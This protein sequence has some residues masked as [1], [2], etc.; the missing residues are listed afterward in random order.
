M[1][2]ARQQRLHTVWFHLYKIL[3]NATKASDRKQIEGQGWVG[4]KD[5]AGH[6]ENLVVMIMFTFLII[7]M[8]SRMYTLTSKQITQF[9]YMHFICHLTSVKLLK[10]NTKKYQEL[11]DGSNIFVGSELCCSWWALETLPALFSAFPEGQFICAGFWLKPHFTFTLC[12]RAAPGCWLSLASPT[13]W[14]GILPSQLR[15]TDQVTN[16][17]Q[18]LKGGKISKHG[19]KKTK[20]HKSPR[21]MVSTPS[22]PAAAVDGWLQSRTGWT[23]PTGCKLLRVS[24]C[25][26]TSWGY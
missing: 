12:N 21:P 18:T 5:F 8:A 17:A 22:Q 23:G 1:K 20:H 13:G 9:K 2:E 25:T 10:K 15:G 6:E 16:I 19:L 24:P 26:R 11:L 3:E 4:G 14:R 7:V